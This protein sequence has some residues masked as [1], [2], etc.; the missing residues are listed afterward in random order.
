MNWSEAE[1]AERFEERAAIREFEGDE[2]LDL[3]EYRAA[4]EVR[5]MIAPQPLPGWIVEQVRPKTGSQ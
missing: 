1:I 2:R 4:V 5:R 3:A